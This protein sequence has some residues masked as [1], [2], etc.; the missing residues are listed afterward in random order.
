[1][2]K[3]IIGLVVGLIVGFTLSASAN[4]MLGKTVDIIYPL[5]IDGVR[6][7]VDAITIEGTSYIP[8]RSAGEM[9]GYDVNFANEVI[10]LTKQKTVSTTQTTS[11]DLAYVLQVSGV[12]ENTP[13]TSVTIPKTETI[14]LAEYNQLEIGM[15]YEEVV[16]IIGGPGKVSQE[17]SDRISYNWPSVAGANKGGGWAVFKDN[18]LIQKGQIGLE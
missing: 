10:T 5:F 16:E 15:S 11:D 8:V 1:M 3:S 6:C 18:K 14:T 2:K 4:S 7:Q 9:F 17:I 12:T 13:D